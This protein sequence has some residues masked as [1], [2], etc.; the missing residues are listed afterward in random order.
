VPVFLFVFALD[1]GESFHDVIYVVALD[2]VEMEVGGI[3]FAAQ[4]EAAFFIPTE[5]STIVA[6][7]LSEGLEIPSSIGEF[8]NTSYYPIC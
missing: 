6:A 4:E 8:E 2:A 1:N 3:E 7:V 5:R